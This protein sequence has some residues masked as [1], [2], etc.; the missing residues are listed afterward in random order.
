[1]AP[2]RIGKDLDVLANVED[3][4]E[5]PWRSSRRSGREH[6]PSGCRRRVAAKRHERQQM[7][8]PLLRM[9]D[10]SNVTMLPI[11][12]EGCSRQVWNKLQKYTLLLTH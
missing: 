11:F 4:F 3:D 8:V 1:M 6:L 7:P 10:P 5:P 9:P 2:P 12:N